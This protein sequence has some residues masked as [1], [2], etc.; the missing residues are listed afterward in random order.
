MHHDQVRIVP[1]FRQS[2][3]VQPAEPESEPSGLLA[4][5]AIREYADDRPTE[6]ELTNVTN[7]EAALILLEVVQQLLADEDEE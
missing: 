7:R 1:W 4:G 3:V 6:I 2:P 5:V